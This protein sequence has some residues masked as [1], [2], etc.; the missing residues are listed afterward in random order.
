MTSLWNMRYLMIYNT[1]PMTRFHLHWASLSRL[2][3]PYRTRLSNGRHMANLSSKGE[4]GCSMEDDNVSQNVR[5]MVLVEQLSV[6][7]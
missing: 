3:G 2:Y 1:N 7:Q 5:M 4:T 6:M